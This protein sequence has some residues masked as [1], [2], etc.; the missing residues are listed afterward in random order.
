MAKID[1]ETDEMAKPPTTEHPTA[2]SVAQVLAALY[3]ETFGGK[4]RGKYRISSR[5]LR[6]LYGRRRLY[7]EDIVQLSRELLEQGFILIDLDSFY[8]VVSLNAFVNYRRVNDEC[9]G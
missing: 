8:V 9:L 4:E 7:A 2:E 3:E 1:Y 6:E 5:H